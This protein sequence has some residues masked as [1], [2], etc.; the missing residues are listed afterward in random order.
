VIVIAR[1]KLNDRVAKILRMI[2]SISKTSGADRKRG[3]GAARHSMQPEK[4]NVFN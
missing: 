1:L 2:G 4:I 3:V